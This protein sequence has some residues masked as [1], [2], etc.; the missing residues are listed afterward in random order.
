MEYI[1]NLTWDDKVAVWVATS[2]EEQDRKQTGLLRTNT[3]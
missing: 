2:E 1:I 3:S